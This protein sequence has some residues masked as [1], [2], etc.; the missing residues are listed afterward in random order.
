[1]YSASHV[2][3]ATTLC[4]EL[5]QI[6]AL[7]YESGSLLRVIR[8]S[9]KACIDVTIYDELFVTSINEKHT[10]SPFQLF[11]DVL[12]RCLVIQSWITLVPPC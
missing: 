8:I 2:Y 5:H 1:M 7:L 11:Q 4:L 9:V 3:P 10:L 12:D 6:T